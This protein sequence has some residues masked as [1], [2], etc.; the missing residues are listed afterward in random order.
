M[1]KEKV[2]LVRSGLAQNYLP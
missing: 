1:F 2:S